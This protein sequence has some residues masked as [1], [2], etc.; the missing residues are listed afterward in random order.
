LEE[1]PKNIGF[2]NYDLGLFLESDDENPEVPLSPR[3]N[4]LSKLLIQQKKF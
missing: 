4:H 2:Q 1:K 3:T